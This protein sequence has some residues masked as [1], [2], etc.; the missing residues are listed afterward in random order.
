M[1]NFQ[2][3]AFIKI[4]FFLNFENPQIFFYSAKIF[5]CFCFAMYTKRYPSKDGNAL[6][7]TVPIKPLS[8]AVSQGLNVFPSNNSNMVFR[9]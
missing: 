3:F 7:P 2:K 8:D 5:V 1:S 9:Q 4:K 6:F